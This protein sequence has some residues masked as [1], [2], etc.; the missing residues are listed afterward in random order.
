VSAVI[1]AFVAHDGSSMTHRARRTSSRARE[2]VVV[3]VDMM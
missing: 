2:V 1:A 3:V